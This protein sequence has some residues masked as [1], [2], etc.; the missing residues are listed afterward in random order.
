M[1]VPGTSLFLNQ[2]LVVVD[3]PPWESETGFPMSVQH[4]ALL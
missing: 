2:A 3:S 4:V 1:A